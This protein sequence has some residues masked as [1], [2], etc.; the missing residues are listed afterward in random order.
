MDYSLALPLAISFF[1]NQQ[2]SF[3]IDFKSSNTSK[4]SINRYILHVIFFPQLIAGPIVKLNELYSSLD[5]LF[6]NNKENRR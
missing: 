3:L 4:L 2:I 1:S 5:K 6:L